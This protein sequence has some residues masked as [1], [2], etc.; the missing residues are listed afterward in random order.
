MLMEDCQR[1]LSAL[2]PFNDEEHA[3]LNR[4][5]DYGEIDGALLTEDP[6]LL[7]QINDQPWLE[8]KA[9]NVRQHQGLP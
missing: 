5:L 6:E 7:Q 3:F 2:L 9:Q 8:W 1:A 4:L